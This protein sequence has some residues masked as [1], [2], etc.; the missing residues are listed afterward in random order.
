M[1]G[2][3]ESKPSAEISGLTITSHSNH[4]DLQMIEEMGITPDRTIREKRPSL[5]SAVYLVMAV[6]RMRQGAQQWREQVKVRQS[7]VK[8][9]EGMKR[10]KTSGRK[11]SGF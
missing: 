4:A 8:S 3:L 1:H 11:S 9:L 2:K 10:G 6:N 7:L 5:R